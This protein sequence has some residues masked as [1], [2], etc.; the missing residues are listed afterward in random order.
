M[1]KRKEDNLN[2]L[3]VI[4]IFLLLAFFL[5]SK[6]NNGGGNNGGT[7]QCTPGE[8]RCSGI[9]NQQFQTCNV[10]SVWI[11]HGFIEGKCG[12]TEEDCIESGYSC[13]ID[14]DCCSNKCSYFQCE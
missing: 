6:G 14:S 4:G 7:I 11:N 10:N 1:V 3:I 13:S 2:I 9:N 12:W 8:E 5:F